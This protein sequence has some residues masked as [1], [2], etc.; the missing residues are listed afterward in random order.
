MSSIHDIF[1]LPR[2]EEAVFQLARECVVHIPHDEE[3][4]PW[5][6]ISTINTFRK[7][8]VSVCFEN[9][10]YCMRKPEDWWAFFEIDDFFI[11]LDVAHDYLST[12]LLAE[13]STDN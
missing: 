2:K 4:K 10:L 11:C 3:I 6:L 8:G 7:Y 1:H 5:F 9:E 12:G 13:Y